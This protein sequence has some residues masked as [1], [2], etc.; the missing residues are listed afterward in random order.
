M[1]HPGT[2]S[3]F[4][5]CKSYPSI[6]KIKFALLCWDSCYIYQHKDIVKIEKILKEGFENICDWFVDNKLSNHFGD[7]KTKSILFASKQ[8]AKNIRKLNIRHKEIC[9]KQQAYVTNLGL[10]FY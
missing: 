5:L 1:F 9:I 2:S 6:S 7:N 8:R 3:V 10:D 4:N